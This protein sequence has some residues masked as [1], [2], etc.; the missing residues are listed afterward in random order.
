MPLRRRI[1]LIAQ[2]MRLGRLPDGVR[3]VRVLGPLAVALAIIAAG[4]ILL[5]AMAQ[6]RSSTGV[7]AGA[8]KAASMQIARA[9][10]HSETL[11][12]GGDL[13][14]NMA[15]TQT[16]NDCQAPLNNGVC[17]RYSVVLDEQPV[18]VGYGVVPLRTVHVTPSGITITVD[19]SKVP[20]FV[21]VVGSGGMIVMNWKTSSSMAKAN[22]PY[23]AAA[24]GSIGR[25][26]LPSNSVSS[27]A[28]AKAP[29]DAN[30]GVI[31]TIIMR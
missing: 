1:S 3:N 28:T 30:S 16:Q 20:G 24:Q 4:A 22:V 31:A 11:Y 21:N 23:K 2:R 7:N 18:M 29:A 26:S 6:Q 27:G 15:I 10:A 25:Y 12:N 8:A 17:L 13:E 9:D 5:G 14:L 19:T